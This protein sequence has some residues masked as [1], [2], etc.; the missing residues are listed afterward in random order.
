MRL[1]QIVSG[2]VNDENGT[3]HRLPCPRLDVL[4]D[5]LTSIDASAKIIIWATFKENYKQIAEVCQRVGRVYK[6][7]HG[8]ISHKDRE[9][10]MNEFRTDPSVTV[11]IANQGAGGVGVNLVEA[12][13]SIYYS[14][15]FK[16]EDDLQSSARN[17]RGGSEMH[18]KITRIDLVCNGT[19]D[20]LIN[21]AL[22]NKEQIGNQILGWSKNMQL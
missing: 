18:S 22:E 9:I 1:Q 2:F 5:L 8:D 19:I 20:E 3:A 7:L 4:E 13:Y 16:L 21:E 15:G 14:K 12:S 17:Y 11:M 6:E 10:G